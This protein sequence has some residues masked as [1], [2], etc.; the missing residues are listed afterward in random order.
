MDSRGAHQCVCL[1]GHTHVGCIHTKFS[2][3]VPFRRAVQ[4]CGPIYFSC[5]RT[6]Q[7]RCNQEIT[8][9]FSKSL[10]CSAQH[11]SLFRSLPRW[12]REE[13][14]K[15]CCVVKQRPTHFACY[16]FKTGIMAREPSDNIK[17]YYVTF[18]PPT[19]HFWALRNMDE[20]VWRCINKDLLP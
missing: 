2:K 17:Q 14:F 6:L 18:T 11:R 19:P 10:L 12:A 15:C 4:R 7:L 3:V 8:F 20:R 9:D 16:A 5:F 13:R 1:T